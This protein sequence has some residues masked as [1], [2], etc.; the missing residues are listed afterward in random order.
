MLLFDVIAV[1]GILGSF[2]LYIRFHN[3]AGR[4]WA[5]RVILL[6]QDAE[7]RARSANR[8]LAR[9]KS[10][11]D[12]KTRSL[13]EELFTSYLS[14]VPV[15]A[16]TAY[17]GIGPGTVSKLREAGLASLAILR[18][19]PI[20]I[21][22]LG[23]KRLSDIEYAVGNLVKKAQGDFDAGVCR[24]AQTLPGRLRELSAQYDSLEANARRREE[25]ANALSHSLGEMVEYASKV[26][27]WHWLRSIGR[28][29][30]V[31]SS[32]LN[33]PLPALA[34]VPQVPE[35]LAVESCVTETPPIDLFL[36]SVAPPPPS[37]CVAQPATTAVAPREECLKVLGI[38]E[39]TSLSAE[40]VRR[41]YHLLFE[42]VSPEKVISMGPEFVA[43]AQSKQREI[44]QATEFLL[45]SMGEKLERQP[46]APADHDL[47]HNPDLDD[48]FGGR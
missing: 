30:L 35:A 36:S 21:E 46:T 40:L 22:G 13:R 3:S 42:R 45:E 26:T 29:S 32:L 23:Q 38:S 39:T 44:R 8:E 41:Q 28:E 24:Q 43:L 1:T 33:A 47:R 48:V 14:D 12:V 20:V 6:S 19:S 16:L 34:T 31:P 15:D 5:I 37:Q 4:R 10:T 17:P 11:R 27:F 9:L 7:K 18:S 2:V 25:A